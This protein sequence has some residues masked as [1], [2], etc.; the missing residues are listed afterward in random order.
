MRLFT[1]YWGRHEEG[2]VRWADNFHDQNWVV[3]AD[4]LQDVICI[5]QNEYKKLFSEEER[6]KR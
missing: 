2:E 6:N 5:L 4:A 1:A 3:R